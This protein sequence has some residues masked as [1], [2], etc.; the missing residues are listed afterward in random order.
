MGD[1]FAR[2]TA[3]EVIG[4]DEG[5]RSIL[6]G[7]LNEDH[8]THRD[9][10]PR[11]KNMTGY[12]R[13]NLVVILNRELEAT[14]YYLIYWSQTQLVFGSNKLELVYIFFPGLCL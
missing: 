6:I 8:V 14:V 1:M 2:R 5:L 3:H 9:K 10:H 7:Q 12:T 11:I 4:R 13:T